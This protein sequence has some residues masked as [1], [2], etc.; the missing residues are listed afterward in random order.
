MA[1][2]VKIHQV[3]ILNISDHY[4]RHG[5][6]KPKEPKRIVGALFGT[7][8]GRVVNVLGSFEVKATISGSSL[9]IEKLDYDF[10]NK[11]MTLLKEANFYKD[12]DFLGWYSTTPDMKPYAKDMEIHK[13]YYSLNENPIYLCFDPQKHI[14]GYD[15]PIKTYEGKFIQQEKAQVETL[16]EVSYEVDSVKAEI[17]SIEHLSKNMASAQTSLFADNMSNSVNSLQILQE[18]IQYLIDYIE[19]NP[20]VKENVEFMRE[21]KEVCINFPEKVD[22]TYREDVVTEFKETSLINMLTALLVANKTIQDVTHL[23]PQFDVKTVKAFD[24]F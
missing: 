4:T 8:V 14:K 6:Q 18:K 15:L 20:K 10:V 23:R 16:V 2:Q 3:V 9:E 5:I 21:L 17:V 24:D 1:L 7:Q 13:G 22:K 11:K 12:C 19:K